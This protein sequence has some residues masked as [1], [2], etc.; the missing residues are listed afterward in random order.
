MNK[1]VVFDYED[2]DEYAIVALTGS[3]DVL[4]F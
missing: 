2:G 4:E 3:V 1:C